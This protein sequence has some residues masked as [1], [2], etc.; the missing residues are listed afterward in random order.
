MAAAIA[1]LGRYWRSIAFLLALLAGVAA[2][3]TGLGTGLEQGL[4]EARYGLRQHDAPGDLVIVEI[5]ARS[6]AAIDRWPWPRRNYAIAVDRLRKAAVA[7]IAFDVDFSAASS[8]ADDKLFADALARSDGLVTL[9]TFRQAAEFAHG[10]Y[11]DS[12]PIAPL[13]EHALAATVSILPDRD[14]DVRNA[15]LGEITAGAPRPSL[16]A[17]IAGRDG[18]AGA[19]FPIDFA[20]DPISIPRLSFIDVRDGRVDAGKLRGKR[21]LIGATAIELGDRYAVP[22]Y[23]VIPGVVIQALAALTLDR[24]IPVRAGWIPPLALVLLLALLLL[25]ARS[26][27]TLVLGG[28]GVTLILFGGA[29]AAS[30]AGVE[31]AL[32][33][34]LLALYAMV[35]VAALVRIDAW[36]AS[37]RVVDDETGLPNQHA[38]ASVLAGKEDTAVVAARIADYDRLAATVGAAAMADLVCRLRDRISVL[39]GGIPVYRVDDRV[40]AWEATVR[41]DQVAVRHDQLRVIMMAPIEVNGRRVDVAVTTGFAALGGG[42]AYDTIANASMAADLALRSG[43]GWHVHEVSDA[44]AASAELSLAGELDEAIA[45]GDVF[46]A[47]QPKLDLKSGRIVSVEALVRWNHRTHGMLPPDHFIPLLERADRIDG[48]TLHVVRA[49]IADVQSWQER[50]RRLTV[51]I[52]LSAVL[53]ESAAF[54]EQLEMTLNDSG[55]D[56]RLLTFEVTESAAMH[57]PA[58]A[59]AALLRFK[60]LGVAISMD[61][62]GT[63]Q[64]TLTYLKTLPLDELKIDRS[65]VE[66]AHQNRG[67]AVL[68]RSTVNLAHELGLKVVA[69][70]VE[71]EEC[72][73]FLKSVGCDLAQGYLISKPV[74]ADRI[75]ELVAGR[76]RAAAA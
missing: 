28:V 4:A 16:A 19:D 70:G 45:A 50:G 36:L 12:M 2:G 42:G 52:N 73:E 44:E 69:E 66:F 23:G 3:L 51:A 76:D 6:I 38:L 53:L 55:I 39:G 8:P 59:V 35:M 34:A 27:K 26:S 7:S 5:D 9:P 62:Y 64:S 30:A 74:T 40:L 63:G 20:I 43:S 17:M 68:V 24:G 18:K 48:L 75:F 11:V 56:P 46:A 37:R 25:R 60:T 57:A 10:G 31:V 71:T 13:R 15:P 49:A 61:D 14:G 58:A 1:K 22:R 32:V 72:L 67:D 41:V 54:I 21:V 65:F 33:P 29:V 47:Y